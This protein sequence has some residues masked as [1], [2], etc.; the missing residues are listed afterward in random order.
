M[1][2]PLAI[3]LAALGVMLLSAYP[4]SAQEMRP[5]STAS[6]SGLVTDPAGHPLRWARVRVDSGQSGRCDNSGHFHVVGIPPGPHYVSIGAPG[7]HVA[8]K[9]VHFV[10]G[11]NTTMLVNLRSDAGSV[12]HSA[13][14]RRKR[15]R[16]GTFYVQVY[17][18]RSGYH[19]FVPYRVEVYEQDNPSRYW[20]KY[21]YE[22]SEGRGQWVV[23]S[24]APLG[25]TYVIRAHWVARPWH[26][27]RPDDNDDF[28]T[29][30]WY[31]TVDSGGTTL[32][33][34]EP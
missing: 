25:H 6:L 32:T 12:S 20:Q 23:C 9:V 24:N 8:G 22:G 29:Q 5:G 11:Q 4:L 31:R 7:H 10:A 26:G 18:Y 14:S 33:F 19:F 3:I 28:V 17:P 15:V 27:H 34:Y 30:E 16:L 13:V 21:W 2:R 1:T